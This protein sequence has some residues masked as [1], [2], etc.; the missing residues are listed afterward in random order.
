MTST[1]SIKKNGDDDDTIA[2]IVIIV[3]LKEDHVV[4]VLFM[5]L[6]MRVLCTAATM[7]VHSAYVCVLRLFC[8][9]VSVC[10]KN[11]SI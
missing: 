6:G 7:V 10:F 5:R 8:S 1:C 9:F 2:T 3:L 11:Q 4:F